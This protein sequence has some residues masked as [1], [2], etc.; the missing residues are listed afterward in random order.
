MRS[1]R[2]VKMTP[3][4]QTRKLPARYAGLVT[5]IFLSLIMTCVVSFISVLR[6]TGFDS[7]VFE[8][9]P[10]TWLLSWLIAFPVLIVAAPLARRMAAALVQPATQR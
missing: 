9:W 1:T 7:R 3:P 4:N 8:L 2:G 6:S 5:S 10:S